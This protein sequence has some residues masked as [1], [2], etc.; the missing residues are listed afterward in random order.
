MANQELERPA[1]VLPSTDVTTSANNP[2]PF[3]DGVSPTLDINQVRENI[4]KRVAEPAHVDLAVETP[5]PG[6]HYD[7][8]HHDG[9]HS[10]NCEPVAAEPNEA[11]SLTSTTDAQG[12]QTGGTLVPGF[13]KREGDLIMRFQAGLRR[14]PGVEAALAVIEQ[15]LNY[16]S[17]IFTRTQEHHAAV[18]HDRAESGA[19]VGENTN[20]TAFTNHP[21]SS[22]LTFLDKNPSY[23]PLAASKNFHAGIIEAA[24]SLGDAA[25]ESDEKEK[26]EDKERLAIEEQRTHAAAETVRMIDS[27][28]GAPNGETQ[29]IIQKLSGPF[30]LSLDQAIRLARDAEGRE[31]AQHRSKLDRE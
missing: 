8:V 30:A 1:S 31:V 23:D 21:T 19:P 16:I 28:S 2:E 17:K 11:S 29:F 9:D 7:A 18:Q 10:R 22:F 4:L 25:Q 14:L 26:Q 15:S 6:T 24:K 27:M 3:V 5:P 20:H 13:F 12:P